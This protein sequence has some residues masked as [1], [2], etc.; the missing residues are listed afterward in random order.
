MDIE[1]FM[2]NKSGDDEKVIKELFNI[3][4]GIEG[5]TD[6][7]H[8]QIVEI[9]KLK[10]VGKK[11]KISGINEFISDF[12]MLSVSKNRLGRKEFIQALQSHKD[13]MENKGLFS[14]F[15]REKQI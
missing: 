6:L 5:K 7:S 2:A 9:C 10:H 1:E 13:H 15:G 4:K 12:M 8:E 3:K 14:G 11:Y